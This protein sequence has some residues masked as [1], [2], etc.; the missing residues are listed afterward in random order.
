[1]AAKNKLS[2]LRDHLF[3]TIEALKDEEKPMA[4]DRAKAI[5]DVAQTIIN[6]AKVEVDFARAVN[7]SPNSTFFGPVREESRELP[8]KYLNRTTH[9]A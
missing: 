5:A 8:V 2:D 4:L 7:A 1:M 6:S 9:T 3:E